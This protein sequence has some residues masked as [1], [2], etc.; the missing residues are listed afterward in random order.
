[1]TRYRVWKSGDYWRWWCPS[2]EH[3][4]AGVRLHIV[5]VNEARAHVCPEGEK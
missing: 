1:M 4:T 2:C 5:A 3:T